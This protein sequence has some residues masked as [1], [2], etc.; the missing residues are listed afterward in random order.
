MTVIDDDSSPPE[1]CAKEGCARPFSCVCPA[2]ED[3]H[4]AR[5]DVIAPKVRTE[6]EMPGRG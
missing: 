1:P 2:D 4:V 5:L 3:C 6:L